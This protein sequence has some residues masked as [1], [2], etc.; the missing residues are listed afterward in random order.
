MK[1]LS[2]N[3]NGNNNDNYNSRW[4]KPLT[5]LYNKRILQFLVLKKDSLKWDLPYVS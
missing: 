2:T 3:D 1:T 4:K 5:N